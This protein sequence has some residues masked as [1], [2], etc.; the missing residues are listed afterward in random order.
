MPKKIQTDPV[1]PRLRLAVK[2]HRTVAAN[3]EAFN[4]CARVLEPLN[5]KTRQTAIKALAALYL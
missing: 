3:L 2:S 1:N 4:R 5:K